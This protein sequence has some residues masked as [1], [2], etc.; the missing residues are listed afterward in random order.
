METQLHGTH[1]R[2]FDAIFQH[3][4][5]RNLTWREVCSMLDSMSDLAQEVNGR[6]LKLTRNGRTVILHRP[7]KKGFSDVQ[8]VMGLRRF[9][10]ASIL[11]VPQPRAAAGIHLLVAIDHRMARV[12]QTDLHGSIPQR[13]VPFDQSGFGRHL[14][15]VEDDSNGQRKPEIASFYEAIAKTLCGA[16]QILLFGSGTGASSAMKHLLEELNR[17]HK[18]LADRVIASVVVDQ[19]HLTEDQL[20]AEARAFY[21]GR[22][23][24]LT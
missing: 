24:G 20:L 21:A 2:T 16:E 22:A 6:A 13:I 7:E 18:E 8:Q 19:P 11:P 23:I 3:P 4:V 15:H 5:A 1:Q 10:E 17:N 12:Y 9:L 14:H